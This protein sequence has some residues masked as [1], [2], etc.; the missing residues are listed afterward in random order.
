MPVLKPITQEQKDRWIVALKSNNYKQGDC[1]LADGDKY[2]CLGVLAE[3]NPDIFNK[4]IRDEGDIFYN[5]FDAYLGN[6]C[7]DDNFN[8]DEDTGTFYLL[9]EKT[10]GKL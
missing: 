3:I 2:C 8:I 6:Y 1:L 4:N 7:Y 9:D 5:D 10:Q